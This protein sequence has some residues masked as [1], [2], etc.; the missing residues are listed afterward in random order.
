MQNHAELWLSHYGHGPE[1]LYFSQL[2]QGIFLYS[3]AWETLTN[4]WLEAVEDSEVKRWLMICSRIETGNQETSDF[5][6]SWKNG[7][8][9]LLF[10]EFKMNAWRGVEKKKNTSESDAVL[11]WRL[12]AIEE[13]SRHLLFFPISSKRLPIAWRRKLLSSLF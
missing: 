2:H 9:F 8:S 12:T 6:C 4:I 10:W 7:E 3:K 1:R 11:I 13:K 5:A